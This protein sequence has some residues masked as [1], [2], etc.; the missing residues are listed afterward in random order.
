MSMTLTIEDIAVLKAMDGAAQDDAVFTNIPQRLFVYGL[1]SRQPSGEVILTKSG[2]RRLF[3]HACC[4]ALREVAEGAPLAP[5]SGTGRWLGSSGF[6]ARDAVTGALSVTRRGQ[7]WLDS[8]EDDA[9]A[10]AV[11]PSAATFASRRASAA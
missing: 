9:P 11:P 7:V 2:N 3:Q 6:V 10:D 5:D 1:I 8:F 4:D